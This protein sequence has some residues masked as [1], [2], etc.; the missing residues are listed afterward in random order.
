MGHVRL[1][2]L[3][4]TRQW[5]QVVGLLRRGADVHGL[6]AAV[7]GAAEEQLLLARGD[8]VLGHTLWLLTQIPLAARTNRFG[9]ELRALGFSP[10]SEQSLLMLVTGFSRAVDSQIGESGNRTDLGELA[11]QAASE[12]LST[13]VGRQLPSL[14]SPG[15]DDV[16]IE[17][18][19]FA[20]KDRFAILARD[21]FTRLTQKT[22]DY[23]VSRI[24]SDHV[25]PDRTI[26][27]LE[28]QSQFKAALEKHC[29]ESSV[30]VEQFAGGWFSKARFE[31]KLTRESSQRFADYALKKMRD[32]LRA[33]S[34]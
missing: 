8:P 3:P 29:R 5:R 11:R 21:F 9:A 1:G 15:S 6:A 19:K 16:R 13:L 22:L 32:E 4:A 31:G 14:F 24:L 17:I 20:T 26:E 18:A 10:G 7:A 25:G 30:I 33:R 28:Q 2:K 34:P 12:S 23:Y 27:T